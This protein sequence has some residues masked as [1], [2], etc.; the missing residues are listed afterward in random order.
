[1]AEGGGKPSTEGHRV[2]VRSTDMIVRRGLSDWERVSGRGLE[3]G[4]K[5]MCA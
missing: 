3:R 1:M 4:S 5:D 2:K